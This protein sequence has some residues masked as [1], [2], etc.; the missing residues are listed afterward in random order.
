M[1][2]DCSKTLNYV[3][4]RKR[5]CHNYEICGLGCPLKKYRLTCN[6]MDCIT[7]E[8]IDIVQKWSDEHPLE[9][10]AERFFK[11]FPNA[12]KNKNNDPR[13]CPKNLGWDSRPDCDLGCAVCWNRPYREAG[14]GNG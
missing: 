12:P 11:M 4:E 8:H 14:A 3:A 2:I 1:K 6:Q 13:C 10:M 9:S 7:Q 5:M